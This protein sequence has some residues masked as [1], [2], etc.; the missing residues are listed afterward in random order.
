M[1]Y[2]PREDSYLLE[3]AVKKYAK[4]KSFLDMGSGSGIQAKAALSSKASSVLAVDINQETIDKLNSQNIP[5]IKSNL[6]QKVKGKFDIIAFNPPY[7]PRDKREPK[8]SQLTTTG[9]KKG[10]EIT[11]KFLKQSIKHLNK[12]GT[13]FLTISSLTPRDRITKLLN[14][15]SLSHKILESKKLFFES[16]EVWEI[17]HSQT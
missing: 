1:I 3:K 16:L 8:D 7:L 15:L 12:N 13:I 11:L 6:F 4:N 14:K 5:A 10:D 9:G 2:E 17:K